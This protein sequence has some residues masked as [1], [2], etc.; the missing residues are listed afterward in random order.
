MNKLILSNDDIEFLLKWRDEHKNLVRMNMSPLNAI[1]I[2]CQDSG[3][4]ITGIRGKSELSL[5]I[6]RNGK[7]LGK[8]TY[9][10]IEGGMFRLIKNKTKLSEEDQQS[11]LTVYASAMA[12]LLFGRSTVDFEQGEI[13]RTKQIAKTPTKRKIKSAKTY[14]KTQPNITYILH[15]ES[16][17]PYIS[18]RGSHRSPRGEFSVRGHFRHYKD[19]KVVWINQY[20]KGTGKPKSTTYKLKSK[21]SKIF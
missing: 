13:R 12:L 18:I 4:T 7:S 6:S 3:Y 16:S 15:R 19:G 21:S 9:H 17:E 20:I 5:N 1:K 14:N 10:L 2:I 8:L 11:C